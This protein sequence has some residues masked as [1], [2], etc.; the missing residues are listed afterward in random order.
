[1][2]GHDWL[3]FESLKSSSGAEGLLVLSHVEGTGTVTYWKV[4]AMVGNR[5]VTLDPSPVRKHT[6][7][8]YGYVD[9][10]DSSVSWKEDLIVWKIVG[11]SGHTAHCC[12]DKPSLQMTFR[13]SGTGIRLESVKQL[14]PGS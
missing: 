3:D 13:F 7:E 4:L 6:L 5:I 1:M 14:P 11:Y 8:K 2:A 10:G 12:P 9:Y